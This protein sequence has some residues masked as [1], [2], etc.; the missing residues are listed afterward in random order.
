MSRHAYGRKA[1]IPGRKRLKLSQFL[2]AAP[3]HP[4]AV[5]YGQKIPADAWGMRLNGT[6]GTCMAAAVANSR[7]VTTTWLTDK[8]VNW[9]DDQVAEFYKTQN[10][11]FPNQDEGMVMQLALEEAHKN[12]LPELDADGNPVKALAF[13]QVDL[14]NEDEVDAAVAIFGG[15]LWGVYV[16]AANEDEF[17]LN[18][19]WD[20][21][22]SQNLGGHAVEG[23]GY[24]DGQDFVTWATETSFTD[25]FRM[26]QAEECWIVIWPEHLGTKQFQEGVDLQALAE[27]YTE[28]TGDPFPIDAP[29]APEP[30]PTPTPAPEPDPTPVDPDQQLAELLGPDIMEHVEKNAARDGLSWVDYVKWKLEGDFKLR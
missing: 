6:Y 1:P 17:D 5:D 19:P 12:G 21:V 30:T 4:L 8:P 11:D 29:P 27:A 28:L 7:L 2:K 24:E 22:R 13:A 23:V 20:Y 18:Q 16:T 26:H 3:S 15:V 25:A 9:T 10:P 14:T